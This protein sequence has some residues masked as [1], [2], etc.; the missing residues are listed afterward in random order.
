MTHAESVRRPRCAQEPTGAIEG[1]V[2]DPQGA[3]VPNASVTAREVEGTNLTRTVTSNDEG[4]YK[5]AQ[6]PPDTYEVTVAAREL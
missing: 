4:Q 2:T 6:L 5:L 1:T 3:I